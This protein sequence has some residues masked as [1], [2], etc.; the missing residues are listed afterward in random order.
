MI[1]MKKWEKALRQE[2]K[3]E[4]QKAF[5]PSV[6]AAPPAAVEEARARKT[7]ARWLAPVLAAA[8]VFCLVLP[9]L[10][11]QTGLP[12]VQPPASEQPGDSTSVPSPS[13][14]EAPADPNASAVEIPSGPVLE[15]DPHLSIELVTLEQAQ[16]ALGLDLK[17]PASCTLRSLRL[18]RGAKEVCY[19]LEQD[20]QVIGTV[21]IGK[22]EAA[23]DTAKY[24]PVENNRHPFYTGYDSHQLAGPNTGILLNWEGVRY[25]GVFHGLPEAQM[26]S[27][28]ESLIV[29]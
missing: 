6:P 7:L 17:E 10:L 15:S 27:I 25:H 13:S 5:P 4:F 14:S 29:S 23:I 19:T 2:L 21:T 20:G 26:L 1:L 28:M 12:S 11:H 9:L 16:A 22:G 3:K 24:Q 8:F 18:Y